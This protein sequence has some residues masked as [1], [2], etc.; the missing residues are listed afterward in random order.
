MCNREKYKELQVELKRAQKDKIE[1]GRERE[2]GRADTYPGF[3]PVCSDKPRKR[4]Q[5]VR[6]VEM[7]LMKAQSAMSLL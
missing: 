2:R 5:L 4:T 3:P 7:F 6:D 1:R